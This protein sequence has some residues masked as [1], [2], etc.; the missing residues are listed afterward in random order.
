MSKSVSNDALWEKLSGIEEKIN[1]G[2]KEQN[3][4]APSPK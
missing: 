1:K 3:A 2:F 4:P